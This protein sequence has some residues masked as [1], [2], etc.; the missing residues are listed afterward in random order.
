MDSSSDAGE[1]GDKGEFEE[2]ACV[3][4]D[5][6]GSH[7]GCFWFSVLSWNMAD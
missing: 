1:R 7:V 2:V 4:I 5:S 3:S 6:C